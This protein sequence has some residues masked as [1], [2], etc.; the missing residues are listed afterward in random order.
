MTQKGYRMELEM[1]QGHV[2]GKS[3]ANCVWQNV[4]GPQYDSMLVE[5]GEQTIEGM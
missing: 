5:K 3:F 4:E 1:V 2:C